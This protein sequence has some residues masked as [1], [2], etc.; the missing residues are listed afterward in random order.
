MTR[1]FL[2]AAAVCTLF[3]VGA[4]SPAPIDSYG[5]VLGVRQLDI[6]FK[7]GGGGYKA[8][9]IL[10]T[11]EALDVP[12]D[13]DADT[14]ALLRLAQIASGPSVSMTATVEGRKV[15]SVQCAVKPSAP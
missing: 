13:S 14:Q 15:L 7:L 2:L 6:G 5:Q 9:V 10:M 3:T 1:R 8:R 12:L 4:A 11:G